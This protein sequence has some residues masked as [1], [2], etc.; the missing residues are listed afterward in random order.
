LGNIG[1][2]LKLETK[3]TTLLMTAIS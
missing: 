3:Y 2:D 1:P